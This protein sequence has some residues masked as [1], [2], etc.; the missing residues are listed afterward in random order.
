MVRFGLNGRH[1]FCKVGEG[2]LRKCRWYSILGKKIN[3]R[4]RTFGNWVSGKRFSQNY[5]YSIKLFGKLSCAPDCSP[6]WPFCTCSTSY[7]FSPF[8]FLLMT[9]FLQ[10][11]RK[12]KP[13]PPHLPAD[14]ICTHMFYLP[15]SCCRWAVSASK[16]N[17]LTWVLDLFSSQL[18]KDV[19]P[20][21]HSPFYL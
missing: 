6:G 11:R 20:V 10:P 3:F 12:L 1:D 21:S 13:Q 7:T 4:Q 5:P 8:Y 16:V 14:N 15:S 18:L 9:W 19:G 2:Q 17:S